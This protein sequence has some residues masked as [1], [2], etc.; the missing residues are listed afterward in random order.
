MEVCGFFSFVL[1]SHRDSLLSQFTLRRSSSVTECTAKRVGGVMQHTH[2][3]ISS[4][5]QTLLL[6]YSKEQSDGLCM[7][8]KFFI[9][10]VRATWR[11]AEDDSV[12]K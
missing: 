11:R 7:A 10:V 3:S 5:N 9:A 1:F 2:K 6:S 12:K 4:G 8:G